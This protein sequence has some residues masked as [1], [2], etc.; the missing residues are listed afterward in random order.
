MPK[1]ESFAAFDQTRTNSM[2][3]CCVVF[4]GNRLILRI[5]LLIFQSITTACLIALLMFN[6]AGLPR[7]Y[8]DAAKDGAVISLLVFSCVGLLVNVI[9]IILYACYG[10]YTRPITVECAGET[11]CYCMRY[12]FTLDLILGFV[13][14]LTSILMISRS[15]C[16]NANIEE[17][18]GSWCPLYNSALSF[19]IFAMIMYGIAIILDCY[20]CCQPGAGYP[21]GG[22][23]VS[24]VPTTNNSPPPKAWPPTKTETPT[25]T[26]VNLDEIKVESVSTPAVKESEPRKSVWPPPS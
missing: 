11:D 13:A 14:G 25:K 3:D 20:T 12:E 24:T 9:W 10:T 22:G 26:G 2:A 16:Q 5:L 23:R 8:I 18:F 1:I 17:V 21:D 7:S 4:F 19:G 15:P 6:S